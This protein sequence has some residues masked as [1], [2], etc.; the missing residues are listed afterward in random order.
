MKAH[1]NKFFCLPFFRTW[2]GRYT[3]Y[4][5]VIF[6]LICFFSLF[7]FFVGWLL[8]QNGYVISIFFVFCV[9]CLLT[10]TLPAPDFFFDD[11]QKRKPPPLPMNL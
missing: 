6:L 10:V 7:S 5:T 9:S 1:I 2:L 4:A 11:R 8:R 3:F